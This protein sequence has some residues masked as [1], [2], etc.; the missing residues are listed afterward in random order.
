M[1]DSYKLHFKLLPVYILHFINF[2]N[3]MMWAPILEPVLSSIGVTNNTTLYILNGLIFAI[4]PFSQFLVIQPLNTL[5]ENIGRQK[6]LLFTQIG[7]IVSLIVA[8]CSLTIP[9]LRLNSIFGLSLSVYLL[10]FARMLD[11]ISGGNVMVTTNYANDL[12]HKEKL[13]KDE[14]FKFVELSIITGSL[15]GVILG[16]IFAS[17]RIGIPG[18]LYLILIIAIIGLFVIRKK[19][20]NIKKPLSKDSHGRLTFKED[21]NIFHHLKMVNENQEAKNI[22]LY[23]FVFHFLFIGF[24]STIFIFLKKFLEIGENGTEV[25]IVMMMVVIVTVLVQVFICPR[26]INKYGNLKSIEI[27]KAVLILALFLFYI[28]SFIPEKL[29]VAGLLLLAFGLLS[30]GVNISLALFKTIIT[31]SVPEEETTKALAIEEQL[32]I[33]AA[34]IS[35]VLASF[36]LATLEKTNIPIQTIFLFFTVIGVIYYY[37]FPVKNNKYNLFDKNKKIS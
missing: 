35:P 28:F 5:S 22:L 24:I 20:T 14:A 8:I 36:V 15:F 33:I 9:A 2:F 26:I 16:P 31:S 7:T 17:T 27:A 13:D 1:R 12:I 30:V 11:G 19:V 29:I 34:T 21:L 18:T 3:L 10:F 37:S 25:S 4:Y 32:M 23:R 6:V